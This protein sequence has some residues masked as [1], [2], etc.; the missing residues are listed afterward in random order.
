MVVSVRISLRVV[1]VWYDDDRMHR[2]CSGV[3]IWRIPPILPFW[4]RRVGGLG[5]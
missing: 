1:G 5:G 3:V 4:I 2:C